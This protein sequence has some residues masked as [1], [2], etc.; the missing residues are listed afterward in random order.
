MHR[1]HR[2]WVPG[3]LGC[4]AAAVCGPHVE[5]LGTNVFSFQASVDVQCGVGWCWCSSVAGTD[6]GSGRL[7]GAGPERS[8]H[9]WVLTR[10]RRPMCSGPSVSSSVREGVLPSVLSDSPAEGKE[11]S[12]SVR[13]CAV[14]RHGWCRPC[15]GASCFSLFFWAESVSAV[16]L[17]CKVM[18]SKVWSL[19]TVAYT[20]WIYSA[21]NCGVYV[22]S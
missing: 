11:H 5:T 12:E 16:Y 15:W 14:C 19:T 7:P 9:S 1:S 17:V 2:A 4:A 8:P 13:V 18:F 6:S 22:A 3:C 10:C 20:R 21:E